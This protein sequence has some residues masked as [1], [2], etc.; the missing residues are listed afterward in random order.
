[1]A[2]E[3]SL[4]DSAVKQIVPMGSE[5]TANDIG[6]AVAY[7]CSQAANQVTG[8]VIAVDGGSSLGRP[9]LGD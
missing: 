3:R 7:L 5:Q 6:E 4:F 1:M 9:L 8:Q 2:P